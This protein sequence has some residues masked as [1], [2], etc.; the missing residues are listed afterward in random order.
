MSKGLGGTFLKGLDFPTID[1]FNC[2]LIF[3]IWLITQLPVSI[4][5]SINL[6]EIFYSVWMDFSHT[7]EFIMGLDKTCL[8]PFMNLK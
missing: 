2:K 6:S 7:A 3:F 5:F 8:G 4:I 1:G